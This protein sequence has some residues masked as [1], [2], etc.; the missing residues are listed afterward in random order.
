MSVHIC[1]T[2][3]TYTYIH[4]THITSTKCSG[5]IMRNY[6]SPPF[7]WRVLSGSVYEIWCRVLPITS[8]WGLPYLRVSQ[9][10]TIRGGCC[11]HVP[12]TYSRARGAPVIPRT[13]VPGV[14]H[15]HGAYQIRGPHPTLEF[16][17]PEHGGIYTQHSRVACCP[18]H[19]NSGSGGSLWLQALALPPAGEPL[20]WIQ[21]TVSKGLDSCKEG[22]P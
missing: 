13:N 10:N 12:K 2:L 1:K 14:A 21:P 6:A 9:H 15:L 3:T 16:R 20:S 8:P 17:I 7:D 22:P 4:N 5:G 18:P 19:S 11:L